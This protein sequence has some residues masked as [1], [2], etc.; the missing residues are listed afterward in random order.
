MLILLSGQ[1]SVLSEAG[2]VLAHIEPGATVGEMGVFTD[3][4]RSANIVST[5]PANA[6]TISK[7]DFFRY[8]QANKATHFKV[9]QNLVH[10]LS[11]R[12]AESNAANAEHVETIIRIEDLLVRYTG[13]TSR[14]LE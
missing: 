1:L 6:I 13:K 7:T 8:L 11:R 2:D 4:P 5:K 9:L 10:V 14:E 12:L 3:A